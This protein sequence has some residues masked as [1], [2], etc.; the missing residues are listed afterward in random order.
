MTGSLICG[1]ACPFG[2]LQDLLGKI[3][4]Q[5]IVLPSWV[6]W[7][8]YVVLVGLVIIAADDFGLQRHPV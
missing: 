4:P 3:F 1:W 7:F 8:R 6:G 5:K 2:F